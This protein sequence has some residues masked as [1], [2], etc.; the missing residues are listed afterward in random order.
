MG[1]FIPIP[2]VSGTELKSFF[3]RQTGSIFDLLN[4][5]VGGNFERASIFAL[6]I[7]PYI[8]ASIVIQLLGSIVPYF[9]KLRKEG[10]DGQKKLNQI[11]RYCTVALAAFNAIT[12][13][14]GLVNMHGATGPV[15]PQPNFLFHLTGVITLV[16]GTMI[17]MWLGEQITEY[18]IGNGISL[19]I[20]AGII[21]RYPEGFIN[22]FRT[23]FNSVSG[24][25]TSLLAIA[26]MILAT[27]AIIFVTEAVRKIPVQYAKR[28]VGRKV[29]GGQSTYIPL[30]VNTAGVIPIIFAQSILMF[31]ATLI[32][33]FQGGEA[34]VGSFWYNMRIWFSPGHWVY[35]IIYVALIIFFA[36]FYTAIV[37][38]PTEM[39]ENMIKYGGH[40]PGKKPGKKT[41]EYISSVLTR[42]TL[43]G[44]V[45]F[46]LIALLPEIMTNVFR[47]PFY[48]GGT[49]LIIV[50]GVALDTLKQIESHLI[51]RH[52]D[53]FMKKGKLKGRTS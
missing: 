15:V 17:V 18:G 38:N 11:T 4:L 51:M 48:F 30:R 9:E 19:I 45:F 46:A 36:Y 27:A 28:I 40:I 10:A 32:T 39:A 21:A 25:M 52:Y 49:G 31:P 42:I 41:A 5:F 1:S 26:V 20:F 13:T 35:T 53:G 50:V 6:G 44:A 16:T 2:G 22:L 43:P 37:L 24:V 12:V 14:V 29:Y 8:T 3:A 33:L 23:R 47:L 7:M 34:E